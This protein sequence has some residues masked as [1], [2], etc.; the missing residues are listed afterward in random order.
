[1][2]GSS[3]L[4][5]SYSFLLLILFYFP[6]FFFFFHFFFASSIFILPVIFQYLALLNFVLFLKLGHTFSSWLYVQILSLGDSSFHGKFCN[7]SKLMFSGSCP[8][9]N[10]GQ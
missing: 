7:L 2:A 5:L 4:I 6:I 10:I 1:M 8:L 9:P 3:L